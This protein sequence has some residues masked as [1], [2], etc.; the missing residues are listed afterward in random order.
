MKGRQSSWSTTGRGEHGKCGHP[1]AQSFWR[2]RRNLGAQRATLD[3]LR[4][5][6][7]R[8]EH[9]LK[10]LVRKFS[11]APRTQ[12]KRQSAQN[13]DEKRETESSPSSGSWSA[14]AWF[15]G[16]PVRLVCVWKTKTGIALLW[17]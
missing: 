15:S 11:K 7:P 14:G 12:G 6:P 5:S 4:F 10:D 13:P 2:S 8:N 3:H 17:L 16:K 9:L 1:T